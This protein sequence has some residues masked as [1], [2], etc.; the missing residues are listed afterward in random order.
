MPAAA[1]TLLVLTAGLLW[2]AAGAVLAQVVP[3]Q[4]ADAPA[5]AAEAPADAAPPAEAPEEAEASAISPVIVDPGI[6][7]EELTLRLIPLTRDDLAALADEWLG[8]V[9]EK[10]EDVVEQ[11]VVIAA[12]DGAVEEAARTRLADLIEE[13]RALFEKYSIVVDSWEKKSGDADAIAGYRA[14]RNSIIVEETRASD[15][16]TL[17]AQALEWMTDKD[18]GVRLGMRIAVVLGSLAALV[19]V[20]RIIRRIARRWVE[21][22]PNLSKLLQAFIVV[23][24][25]WLTIAF[26]LMI[27]LSALGIDITPAFA[28][29]GGASFIMAFALQ[30]TLCNLAAGLMIM[31]N[32]PFDE[33]DYVDIGGVAGTVKSVSIVSTTVTTPDNQVIVVPNSKV[34]GNVI[35]NV[36]AS[37]TRRVDLVFG[38]AYGD[39]IEDAQRVLEKTVKAHPLILAEPE[40]V[41][42]VNALAASSV[43]FICRPWVRS[44]DYW[45]VHWDLT[46]QVKE[47]FD[48]AGISIPFPQTDMHVHLSKDTPVQHV[49]APAAAAGSGTGRPAGA[50]DYARGDDGQDDPDE[51]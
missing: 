46:R 49:L 31:I 47:A 42:R 15:W 8:I 39:S 22:V 20:A 38:I 2:L 45:T 32:R 6:D 10:T 44:D 16:Q 48:A 27:V 4:E 36:T 1:R 9:K 14:Y 5:P 24:I 40:P 35:T 29:I 12:T 19:F 11:Q 18:G 37:A 51:T 43:D 23:L 41:I 13:R 17:A 21:H 50:P 33:G 34:W 7:P 30:D 25:Y 26:G 28:L 3:P